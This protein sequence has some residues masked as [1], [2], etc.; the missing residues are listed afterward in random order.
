[1]DVIAPVSVNNAPFSASFVFGSDL[2]GASFS[3]DIQ[4]D[5]G[6]WTVTADVPWIAVPAGTQSGSA[7]LSP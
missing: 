5:Q 6:T 1:M 4:A 3:R 7:T 2:N